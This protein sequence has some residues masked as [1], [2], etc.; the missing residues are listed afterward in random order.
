MSAVNAVLDR[1]ADIPAWVEFE[2]RPEVDPIATKKTGHPVY[3][4]V[5]YA[6]ITPPYSKD[7]VNKKVTK[8]LENMEKQVRLGRMPERHMRH[9]IDRLEAW[10]KGLEMPV[11]GTAIKNCSIF[12]PAEVKMILAA[13]IRS[14]ESL[15]AC[16]DEGL[17][18]IGMGGMDLRNKAKAWIKSAE[19]NGKAA[20]EIAALEKKCAQQ[21]STI[22]SLE[23]KV[24]RLTAM[25]EARQQVDTVGIDE[26]DTIEINDI[27]PES[28]PQHTESVDEES[29]KDLN[30]Q[31]KAVTGRNPHPR[32]SVH[33]IKARIEKG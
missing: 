5:E 26:D 15:A 21:E 30:A 33:A 22:L 24:T 28:E 20:L 29:I 19:D 8:W 7:C 31:Y 17:K 18:R 13:N 6:L 2:L 14:V 9:G 27:L 23:E 12:T 4:D 1:E 25:V 16:N 10:R 11:D 32:A 3:K